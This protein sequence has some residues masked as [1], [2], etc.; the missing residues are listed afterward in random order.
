MSLWKRFPVCLFKSL[1][2][3]D[4]VHPSHPLSFAFIPQ[5]P[6]VHPPW[7]NPR[8]NTEDAA[9]R[10]QIIALSNVSSGMQVQCRKTI[11]NAIFFVF[12]PSR[13]GQA[14][15]HYRSSELLRISV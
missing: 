12:L 5:A 7:V 10:A 14:K 8:N 2:N 4:T 1:T 11:I 6:L 15:L 13:P 3:S 9:L